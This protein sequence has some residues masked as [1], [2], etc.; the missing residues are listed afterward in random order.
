[1]VLMLG[2]RP[3]GVC[4]ALLGNLG[5]SPR[6][7]ESWLTSFFADRKQPQRPMGRSVSV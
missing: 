4:P 2:D 1:M 6:F 3:G 7:L 5:V